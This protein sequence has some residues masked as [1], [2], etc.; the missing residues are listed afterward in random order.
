MYSK[1]QAANGGLPDDTW[2]TAKFCGPNGG[3]CVEV[4][5]GTRGVIGVRDSK[6][7]AGPVLVFEQAGWGGLLD[8]ARAGRLDLC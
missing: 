6:P 8:A 5:L 2:Q 4:N 1:E 7:V 3:N